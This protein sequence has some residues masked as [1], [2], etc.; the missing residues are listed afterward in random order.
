MTTRRMLMILA[1]LTGLA[2]P[3]HADEEPTAL[4]TSR[5]EIWLGISSF[6]GLADIQPLAGGDFDTT[7]FGLG[8]AWHWPVKQFES[9][10]ILL[11]VDGFI[12][13]NDSSI[14]GSIGDLTARH[15]YLGISAK[16]A[17]GASRNVYLDAGA[18]YHEL[19]MAELSEY[20]Y[21]IEHVAWRKST[22]GAFVGA[23]WDI[24]AGR[25][26]KTAGLSLG[27][28]VHFVDF[29]TVYDKDTFIG[30]ILGN[31]AGDLGGPVYMLQVG[32]GGR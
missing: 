15:L 18:G 22:D 20:W 25:L 13:A 27:L 30:P 31:N 7:G 14:S 29:G 28:K 10:E 1:V 6:P 9:S 23:T 4:V 11:G 2:S 12:A 24:G 19:D 5:A 21:G 17:L 26:G 8:A 16:W 32:Y 3:V